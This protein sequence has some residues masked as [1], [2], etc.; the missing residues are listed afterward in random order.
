[1]T[2]RILS[3]ARRLLRQSSELKKDKEGMEWENEAVGGG[4]S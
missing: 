4:K 3:V 2:S 1:M